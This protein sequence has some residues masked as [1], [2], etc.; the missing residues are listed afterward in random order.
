MSQIKESKYSI[1]DMS[2]TKGSNDSN[3]RHV[4]YQGLIYSNKDMS[5]TNESKYSKKIHVPDQGAQWF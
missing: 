3:K 4:S 1:K 2:Q 5:Q